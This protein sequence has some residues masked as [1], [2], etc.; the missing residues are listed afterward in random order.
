MWRRDSDG[1]PEILLVHPGGPFWAG[2]NDHAWSIP[3]GEFVPD[4]EAP[5]ITARREFAEEMGSE[6]PRDGD[7]IALP[8]VKA[9]GKHIYPF[10]IRGDFDPATLLSNSTVIEWP[11]RSGKQLSIPEVDAAAWV[12]L[13][14][15]ERYLHKGQAKVAELVR[16]VL[17]D[18]GSEVF[19]DLA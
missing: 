6:L 3:K 14:E 1:D 9:S 16:G 18:S 2:K 5:A 19:D 15:A 4:Q 10:L 12:R 13:D 11:P 8:V 7:L 17:L